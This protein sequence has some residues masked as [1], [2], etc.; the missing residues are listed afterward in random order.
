MFQIWTFFL[1]FSTFTIDPTVSR[2]LCLER[3]FTKKCRPLVFESEPVSS[4]LDGKKNKLI[5]FRFG[6]L[7]LLQLRPYDPFQHYQLTRAKVNITM[8]EQVHEQ[9]RL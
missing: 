1:L 2:S 7:A 3:S 8:N 9:P 5:F 4:P 6:D